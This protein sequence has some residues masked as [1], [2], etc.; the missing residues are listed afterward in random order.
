V[1][2]WE[3]DTSKEGERAEGD[4]GTGCEGDTTEWKRPP[5]ERDDEYGQGRCHPSGVG[6]DQGQLHHFERWQGSCA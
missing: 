3:S 4:I 6:V 5:P 1:A 2:A